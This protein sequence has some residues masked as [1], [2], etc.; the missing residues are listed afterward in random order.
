[1]FLGGPYTASDAATCA[2]LNSAG[3][4]TLCTP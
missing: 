2:L 3:C 1:V 4:G